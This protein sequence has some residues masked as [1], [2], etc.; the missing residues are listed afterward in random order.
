[1][2]PKARKK[3][4]KKIQHERKRKRASRHP[5]RTEKVVGWPLKKGSRGKKRETRRF[6]CWA[7][8]KGKVTLANKER[9]APKNRETGPL[10]TAS[11]K[12][13]EKSQN[14]EKGSL[15]DRRR[16]KESLGPVITQPP[17]NY[18]VI[19]LKKKNN[20]GRRERKGK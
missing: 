5:N 2:T 12:R 7:K 9:T 18:H 6:G 10:K 4:K 17:H 20:G 14:K 15:R 8:G 13:R 3:Q 19:K 16:K 1:M 11:Q